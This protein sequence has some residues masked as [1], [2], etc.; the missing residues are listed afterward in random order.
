MFR[1]EVL[2]ISA[3]LAIGA[4]GGLVYNW[5]ATTDADTEIVADVP[6]IPQATDQP[7]E[8][9]FD[10]PAAIDADM[11]DNPQPAVDTSDGDP[12]AAI[13]SEVRPEVQRSQPIDFG[14]LEL[15]DRLLKGGNSIG[16]FQHY[17]KLWQQA[18]LPLDSAVLIRLGLSS[19]LAGLYKQAEDHYRSAIRVTKKG[20][21]QQLTSLLGTARVWERQRQFDEAIALLSELFLL[22]AHEGVPETIRQSIVRQLADCLQKRLLEREIVAAAL[23]IE[24]MEYHWCPLVIEPILE[25]A[26]FESPTPP[27]PNSGSG[28]VLLQKPQLSDASVMLVEAHL[29]AAS[30]LKVISTLSNMAETAIVVTEKAKSVLVGRLVNTDMPVISVSMLLDQMLEPMLLSWS[31]A[32]GVIT[33]MSREELTTRDATSFDLARTQRMLHQVQL[34]YANGI[35]RTA[36]IMNE[37]NNARLSGGWDVAAERYHAAREAGPANELNAKLFFNEASLEML[38]GEK[39]D[40]LHSSYMA[41]DQT[42]SAML[43][44]EVYAMIAELELE[45][46]QPKKAITA[47]SRGLRRADNPKIL[48][49]TAMTLARAYLLTDDPLSA[50]AVLFDTSAVLTGDRMR[51]LASVFGAFARF[52]HVRPKHGLQDEGQRLVMA[53]AAL[54]P[55]DV[56]SFADALIVSEAYSSVGLRSKAIESLQVALDIAPAGYWNERIRFQ[57]AKM[58]YE[59]TALDKANAIVE[60]FAAV[61]SD[62]LPDVLLLHAAIQLDLG[63]LE[64]CESICRRILDMEVAPSIKSQ[65]LDKLGQVL[66]RTGNHYAAALCFAGL[67]PE[68][69]NDGPGGSAVEVEQE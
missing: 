56:T 4:V 48:T 21:V 39:L 22:Y 7:K 5:P 23:E 64:S 43:Q 26:D 44:A 38:R 32:D 18:N 36:A 11:R 24:P 6:P 16:A 1:A 57:L 10:P 42:L 37:G 54:D 25:L 33:I 65:A 28:L 13:W 8:Q 40:A 66:Q 19:E 41:L 3:F 27:V 47:A 69:D 50:N 59:S 31:Q 29:E 49:R 68:P 35:E 55:G 9:E 61:S 20:S 67:L 17:S 52:R 63:D 60:S 34:N 46:G 58:Y 30:P 62:L 53:L 14:V 51:R 2:W 12:T 45:F 15:G